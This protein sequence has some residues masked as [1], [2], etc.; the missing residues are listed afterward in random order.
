[1]MQNTFYPSGVVAITPGATQLNLCGIIASTAGT[2]TITDTKG[3]ST[4][5]TLAAGVPVMVG[6]TKVTAAAVT[7]AGFLP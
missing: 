5:L 4:T 1:M 6:I 2:A 7:V 3:N